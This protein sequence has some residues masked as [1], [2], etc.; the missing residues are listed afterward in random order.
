MERENRKVNRV[1]VECEIFWWYGWR[2][3]RFG[4]QQHYRLNYTSQQTGS[5]AAADCVESWGTMKGTADASDDRKS[6][7]KYHLPNRGSLLTATTAAIA[8]Q[9]SH[10]I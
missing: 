2:R 1:V 7:R 9:I 5:A 3:E 4:K 6:A 8:T 10:F